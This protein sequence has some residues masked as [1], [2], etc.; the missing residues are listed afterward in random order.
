MVLTKKQRE[1]LELSIFEYLINNGF[2]SVAELYKQELLNK[3]LLES[4]FEKINSDILEKK[5]FEFIIYP[6]RC[7]L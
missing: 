5:W 1:E 6:S 7:L 4:D 3:D 2:E